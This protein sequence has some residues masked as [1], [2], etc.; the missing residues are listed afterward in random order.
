M[1]ALR[2]PASPTNMRLT[3]E[4]GPEQEFVHR[5][6]PLVA[7]TAETLFERALDPNANPRDPATLARCGA[8]LTKVV[9]RAHDRCPP[10]PAAPS[11]PG[12]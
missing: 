12:R 3:F 1:T 4:P 10:A 2:A 9:T 5:T 7:A 6:H 11:R 8:W